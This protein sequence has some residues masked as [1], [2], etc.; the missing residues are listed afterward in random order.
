M[1]NSLTQ[2]PAHRDTSTNTVLAYCTTAYTQGTATGLL[3]QTEYSHIF[4]LTYMLTHR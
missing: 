1:S 2:V 3:N 4:Y